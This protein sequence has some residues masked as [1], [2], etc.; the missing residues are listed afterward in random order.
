[1]A[2]QVYL[3]WNAANWVTVVLM[4]LVGFALLGFAMK[5]Y[6]KKAAGKSQIPARGA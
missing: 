2:E 1:M 5:V 4:G 3:D 6:Q